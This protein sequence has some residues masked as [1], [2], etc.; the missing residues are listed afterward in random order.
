MHTTFYVGALQAFIAMG[1][2]L[3]HE[4]SLYQTL[5]DKGKVYLEQELYNGEYF[6]QKMIFKGLNAK[7]PTTVQSFS[8]A[9]SDE[10]KK[11][12]EKEGPKYQYG[13]GC[14]SDGVL[15][16]WISTMCGI[17]DIVDAEKIKNHLTSVHR[18]N[19]KL[20]LSDHANPQ[21]PS[22]ALGNEGGLLLCT[23]PKGGKD[24]RSSEH[25]VIDMMV[26]CAIL[27][28]NMNVGIGMPGRSLVMVTCKHSPACD[29]MQ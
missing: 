21:R 3:G 29:M 20:N 22:F 26:K 1:S 2:Y 17:E 16:S 13:A 10:A 15:G 6:I 19:L 8:G 24:L 7:D 25:P 23:W 28:T 11:L 18:Y 4:I 5:L 27:S 14:L 12:L 9:Y